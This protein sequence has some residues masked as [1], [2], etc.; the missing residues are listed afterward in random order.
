EDV[1]TNWEAIKKAE[2]AAANGEDLT[3]PSVLDGVPGALPALA[4]ALAISKRAV[5]VGFEWPTIEGVLDKLIEE[6]REITEATDPVQLEAE[7]GDW[8]FSAVNLARWR[9]VDPESALRATNARFI[10]RFKI[11]E[12]LAV[13]RGKT[14][15]EM[16][17]EEMDAL[18]DEAKSFE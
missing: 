16:T 15:S 9:N 7:I 17:I 18:W 12:A 6:A 3:L 14:L 2:R 11:L 8:L 1:T 4:Q 5:R 10:R 13:A